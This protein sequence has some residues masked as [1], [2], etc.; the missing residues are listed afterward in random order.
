[1]VGYEKSSADSA[2]EEWF[3]LSLHEVVTSL[4]VSEHMIIE[5]V[6]EGIVHASKNE[7]D[8]W[9]FDSEALRSIRTVLQLNKDLGINVAGA[10]LALELLK[11]IDRLHALL[12][13]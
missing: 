7:Q 12:D 13:E 11:E 4:G 10:G 9:L 6:D 8:E 3:S 5:I 1:M 2:C